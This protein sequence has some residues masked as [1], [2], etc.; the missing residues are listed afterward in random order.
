MDPNHRPE[1]PYPFQ[2]GG[3]R[4]QWAGASTIELGLRALRGRPKGTLARPPLFPGA[5]KLTHAA[6]GAVLGSLARALFRQ[7]LFT[8]HMF[9]AHFSGGGNGN[10]AE[11]ALSLCASRLQE[12]GA[13]RSLRIPL[14]PA[15]F[16]R[17]ILG[18]TAVAG[19]VPRGRGALRGGQSS[20]SL[21]ASN[22]TASRK[23]GTSGRPFHRFRES[24]SCR[25]DRPQPREKSILNSI[26]WASSLPVWRSWGDPRPGFSGFCAGPCPDSGVEGTGR[27]GGWKA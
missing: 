16:T 14:P 17:E 19:W 8:V 24:E 1:R 11:Q 5:G 10:W 25:S 15:G 21:C 12:A 26:I 4:S 20:C 27:P 13:R 7:A 9:S 2:A 22:C 18:R 6:R 23:G 3:R